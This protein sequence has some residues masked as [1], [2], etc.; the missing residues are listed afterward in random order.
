MIVYC[1]VAVCVGA[2]AV[3]DLSSERVGAGECGRTRNTAGGAESEAWRKGARG[4][5][6]RYGEVPPAAARACE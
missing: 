5:D 4:D 2:P 6:H 3:G 1:C